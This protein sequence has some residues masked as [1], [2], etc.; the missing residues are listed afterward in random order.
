MDRQ[1]EIMC[2]D[3]EEDILEI[4]SMALEMLGD[5]KVWRCHS[6]EQ[7]L[8]ELPRARPDLV[9]MDVMM[10]DLDGPGTMKRM[11]AMEGF[12]DLPVVFMTAHVQ[13]D[14]QVELIRQGAITCIS[15]P[16]DATSLAD[17]VAAIWRGVQASRTEAVA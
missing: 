14:K 10:P 5:Y 8:A 2:I 9:L 4:A 7:A 6:G 16:F 15:K 13:K 11:H 1:L 3:D 12:Q 17:T